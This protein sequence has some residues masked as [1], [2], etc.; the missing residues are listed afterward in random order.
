MGFLL[1]VKRSEEHTSELQSRS[2]FVCRLLLEKKKDTSADELG[3]MARQL[4]SM[5][6]QLDLLLQ[7]RQRLATMEER[8]RLARDLHDTVKQQIFAI[9]MQVGSA[10]SFIEYN[11]EE[12]K[13][14]LV[15]IEH[16]VYQAQEE[17]SSLIHQLRPVALT[18]GR[19]A[20]ALS[21]Y[22]ENWSRQHE[23]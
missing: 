14:R 9:A 12:A 2:D 13:S 19:L 6:T 7:T 18:H 3:C 1:S 16:L 22:C 15:T 4:N 11:V 17:L 20:K 5:A 21:E 10:Q 8:N 23:V